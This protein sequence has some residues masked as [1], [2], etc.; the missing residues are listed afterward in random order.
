MPA[1]YGE[2]GERRLRA[3]IESVTG[4]RIVRMDRQIRWRPAWFVDVDRDGEILR[5]HLRGDRE[6]DVSIFPELER[7]AR[8]IEVLGRHGIQVPH[9]H[10]YCADPPAILMEALEGTR[11]VADAADDATRRSIAAEFIASVVAMHRLPV[12]PFVAKGLDLPQGGE[13]IMLAGLDA[14]MP[15]Y[16]RTRTGPEPLLEFVLGWL[17]RNVPQHRT[18]PSFIQFDC[19]QFLHKDGHL[20]GLYDFE[21][22][23]L[24]DAMADLATMRMRDPV[25]PLGDSMRN[26]CRQYEALSGEPVDHD[27]IEFHTLLFATISTMQFAG[28]VRTLVPGDP[29]AVYLEFDLSLRQVML[30][31]LSRLGGFPLALPAALPAR[32]GDNA[33]LIAKIAD[34][35]AGLEV[36]SDL[37]RSKQDAAAQLLEWMSRE[38]DQGAA[39][40]AR[41]HAET[42]ALLGTSFADWPSAEAALEAYVR[43]AGPDQDAALF[44]L[45]AAIEGRRLLVFGPTRIGAAALKVDLA[46]TR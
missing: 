37:D 10:G 1:D 24:G 9:I 15:L 29:H 19:G 45:F 5:L 20:T 30:Q 28:T 2:A 32:L 16:A 36:A 46:P 31:S 41:D 8:V 21:F 17:R 43:T 13:A 39:A 34:T 35:V 27:V 42:G 7:E 33:A 12:E 38:D 22:S 3:F 25:E 26:I 18:R 44:A 40:R 11:I 14:Y 4:G 23:M 6:G